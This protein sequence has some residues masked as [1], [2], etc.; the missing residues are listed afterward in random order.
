MCAIF[1][2]TNKTLPFIYVILAV[3]FFGISLL[4]NKNESQ[5]INVIIC[6]IISI[7]ICAFGA[8]P[9]LYN[10]NAYLHIVEEKITARYGL[11]NRL[12]C[13]IGDV[14]FASAQN[15]TLHLLIKGK[16]RSIF[17]VT[18]SDKVAEYIVTKI[19]FNF[20]GDANEIINIL[21]ARKQDTKKF[22]V[23]TY[24]SV[25]F[26]F[27]WIIITV[28]LTGARDLPEFNRTD[29]TYFSAM[30]VLE[31]VTVVAMFVFAIK[32]GR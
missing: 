19:S 20:D 24:C 5:G 16:K 22:S 13:E 1:K 27:F 30:C 25:G 3:S 10:R 6:V 7:I 18:N 28:L 15:N 31:A 4:I 32:S 8:L 21:K 17:G 12:E 26:S 23:L 29:W 11:F 14:D 9:Y 2:K